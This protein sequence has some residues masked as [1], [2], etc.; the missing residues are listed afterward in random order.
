MKPHASSA[1]SGILVEPAPQTRRTFI[2]TTAAGLGLAALSQLVQG[3]PL[4]LPGAIG[5]RR[6]QAKRVI[7]LHQ[8]GAPSPD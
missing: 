4:P 7:Y 2:Q 3:G 6:K 8:S 5:Q 1:P